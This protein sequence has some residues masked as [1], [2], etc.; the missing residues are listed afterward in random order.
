MK[1]TKGEFCQ[2]NMHTRFRLLTEYGKN[3]LNKKVS[4][5]LISVYMMY[6]FYV[7]VY[8]N[9]V[10]HQLERVEPLGDASCLEGPQE[11]PNR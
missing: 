5:R 10:S 9:L 4:K 1:M 3:V 11:L 6:D 7:E 8:E 2:F